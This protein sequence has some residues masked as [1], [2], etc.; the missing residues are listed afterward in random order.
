MDFNQI[1]NFFNEQTAL[2]KTFFFNFNKVENV[3]RKNKKLIH[4]PTTAV[5]KL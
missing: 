4:T 2:G 1:S 5:P 3:N